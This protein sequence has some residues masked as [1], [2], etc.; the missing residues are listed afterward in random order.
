M[1]LEALSSRVDGSASLP[2]LP[3]EDVLGVPLAVTDYEAAMD[4]TDEVI[5]GG[6]RGCLRAAAVRFVMLTQEDDTTAAAVAECTTV[7]HGQRL[8]WALRALEA[9]TGAAVYGSEL[10]AAA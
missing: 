7:P 3:S 9:L 8:V 5:R 10:K 6:H 2:V 4:W 1:S